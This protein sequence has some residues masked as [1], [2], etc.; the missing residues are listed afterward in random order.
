MGNTRG[1]GQL[2]LFQSIA[3]YQKT[4]IISSALRFPGSPFLDNRNPIGG[5]LLPTLLF[6][7]G[8]VDEVFNFRA[9]QVKGYQVTYTTLDPY[10]KRTITQASGLLLIPLFSR[11]L[12][13]LLFHR[14]TLVNKDW[15]PSLMPYSFSRTNSLDWRLITIF[16]AMQGYIVLVPDYLGYGSSDHILHPYLHKKS[17]TRTTTDMLYAIVE[18]LETDQIPFERHLFVMGYSQGGHGALA[19]AQNFQNEPLDLDIVAVAAGG[20]P[21]D[22]STTMTDLLEQDTIEPIPMTLFLQS[23]SHIY[24]L[25]LNL[26]MK[27][28]NY[29]DIISSSFEYDDMRR[30]TEDLPTKV[31]SLFHSEF[32]EEVRDRENPFPY[33]QNV[34]EDN[35]VYNWTPPFPVFLFHAKKDRIVPYSN[36]EIAYDFFREGRRADV[37]KQDCDFRNL[38]SILGVGRLSKKDLDSVRLQANHINCGLMFALE[39]GHYFSQFHY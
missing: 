23:Y 2:V 17:V 32:L 4:S 20:G 10:K 19:F 25:D 36:T 8:M 16:M 7:N 9:D 5:S 30:A 12:P 39:A 38:G 28:R 3:T 29:I 15:A 27:K 35:S 33:F 37:T 14:G 24:D 1:T 6:N 34:L 13:L 18:K 26:I 31:R 11:P 21:Y 22:L